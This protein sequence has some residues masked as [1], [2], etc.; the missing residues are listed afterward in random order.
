MTNTTDATSRAR[1]AYPFGKP[2]Y[3]AVLSGVCVAQKYE[4]T[5]VFSGVCVAQ[6][7]KYSAVFSG[8]CVAQ[9][10]EYTAVF[11]GV[12][13]APVKYFI[14]HYLSFLIYLLAI[15][16]SILRHP[17]SDYHFDIFKTLFDLGVVRST[18]GLPS[19]R[20]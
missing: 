3:T 2:E 14:H 4:Y 17:A 19:I 20:D 8:V 9:K 10:P 18:M 7:P 1:T 13:V 15:V 12:S 11:S 5:A 6:K 16:L